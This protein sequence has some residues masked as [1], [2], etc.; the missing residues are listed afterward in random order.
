M[1]AAVWTGSRV[2]RHMLTCA[3]GK[4]V[5]RS[6]AA[7]LLGVR[8]LV[9]GT[10]VTTSRLGLLPLV[11]DDLVTM[12]IAAWASATLHLGEVRVAV[13]RRVGVWSMPLPAVPHSQ[14]QG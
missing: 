5:T 2:D 8:L 12:P 3:L 6:E 13:I 1:V 11:A 9:V 14:V 7:L 10:C 4:V